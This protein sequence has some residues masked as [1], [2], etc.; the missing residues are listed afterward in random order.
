[1]RQIQF[2][3]PG[4][5]AAVV[6]CAQVDDPV[7][8]EP[9]D[10]LVRVDLFPINPADLL[11]LQGFYPRGDPYSPS[12]GIEATGTAEAIAASVREVAIGDRVLLITTQTWVRFG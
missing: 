6:V 5:P 4:D 9:D 3:R 7:P 11:T 1:M 12:L 10:V 2:H 8:D